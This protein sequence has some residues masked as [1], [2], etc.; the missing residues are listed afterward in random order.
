MQYSDDLSK[1][2]VGSITSRS[3]LDDLHELKMFYT[4]RIH[5]LA[6]GH[7]VI[8]TPVSELEKLPALRSQLAHVDG[9]INSLQD[10]PVSKCC[11]MLTQPGYFNRYL[12]HMLCRVLIM[13][14]CGRLW[15]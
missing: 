3:L 10:M 1:H 11:M 4:A 8:L 5:C 14:E 13:E 7:D 12:S 6:T 15:H 2:F 9:V